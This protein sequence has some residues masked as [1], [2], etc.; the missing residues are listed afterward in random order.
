M[1]AKKVSKA[2]VMRR[3]G[4]LASLKF[5]RVNVDLDFILGEMTNDYQ[6][7]WAAGALLRANDKKLAD[8]AAKENEALADVFRGIEVTLPR[9]KYMV[10]VMECA[11]VRV[12]AAGSRDQLRRWNSKKAP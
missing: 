4:K 6:N 9:F 5:R 3:A 10:R 2:T 8:F 1:S 12:M 11:R 7:F